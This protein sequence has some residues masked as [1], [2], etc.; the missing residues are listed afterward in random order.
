MIIRELFEKLGLKE[1]SIGQIILDIKEYNQLNVSKAVPVIE[2]NTSIDELTMSQ[3][4]FIGRI[5]GKQRNREF[6]DDEK[7]FPLNIDV[8]AMRY[9]ALEMDIYFR[10][11]NL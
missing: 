5:L 10:K 6:L 8:N 4:P 7:L 1:S 11:G 3:T 9:A 2:L